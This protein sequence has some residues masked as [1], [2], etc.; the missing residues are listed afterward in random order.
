MKFRY[1]KNKRESVGTT[2]LLFSIFYFLS[3]Q[4]LVKPLFAPDLNVPVARIGVEGKAYYAQT[5]RQR[6]KDPYK[7]HITHQQYQQFALSGYIQ[8]VLMALYVAIFI[9]GGKRFDEKF[10]IRGSKLNSE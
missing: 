1:A 2:F 10:P 8:N 5:E 9:I 4:C 3:C 6:G 7:I